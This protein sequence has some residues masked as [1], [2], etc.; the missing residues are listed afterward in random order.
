MYILKNAIKNIFRNK[1]RNILVAVILFAVI[2]TTVVSIIINTTTREIIDDY[3]T[4]FGTEV[5]IALDY[6]NLPEGGAGFEEL[7]LEKQME[8]SESDL[9]ANTIFMASI[10]LR[11]MEM[12]AVPGSV[13]DDAFM[14]EGASSENIPNAMLDGSSMEALS[15]DFES[16]DR[17]LINGEIYTNLNE[18]IIS[19]QLAEQNGLK[20]GD[21]FDVKGVGNLQGGD[22]SIIRLTITGIFEDLTMLAFENN[23]DIQYA[24]MGNRNNQILT[25]FET[26]T[27]PALIS[28]EM[29]TPF[30]VIFVLKDASML[31]AF[32]DEINAKGLPKYYNIVT[33]ED[34]YKKIVGPVENMAGITNTFLIVVLILG[35]VIL[36]VLSSFSI[37]ER[38]YEIGV[39]RAIGMSKIKV[40]VGLLFEMLAMTVVCLA[41]GLFIGTTIAQPISDSLLESQIEQSQAGGIGGQ[42]ESPSN[43]FSRNS[44]EQ[45]PL[46]EVD[47]H[48]SVSAVL[49][50]C[51]VSLLL[52][53]VSSMAGILYITKMEP[54][55]ILS[56]RN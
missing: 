16:G 43:V 34:S 23:P 3:K 40:A 44:I 50:I 15:G 13:P 55:K 2:L 6:R 51:L 33:N 21:S 31:D 37:R 38:K 41:I 30:S 35:T 25:S 14:L 11:L 22:S 9:L 10:P 39:L 52:T 29:R 4:R 36:I 32:K 54:M 17:T 26:V 49:I 18:V 53:I 19:Q 28:P 45:N 12:E 8:F 56:E 47:V 1:G 7:T 27:Q 48:L 42:I 46:S 24:S 5:S 20:V